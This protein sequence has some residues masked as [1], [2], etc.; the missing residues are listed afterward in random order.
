M[1]LVP[2][3]LALSLAA[4]VFLGGFIA[5][6]LLGPHGMHHG[7]PRGPGAFEAQAMTPEGREIVRAAFKAE[8]ESLIASKRESVRLRAQVSEALAAEPFDRAAVE[9]A[10]EALQAEDAAHRRRVATILIA[11]AGKLSPADRKALAE[12]HF[13]QRRGKRAKMMRYFGED[14]GA[15]APPPPAADQPSPPPPD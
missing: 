14:D 4:N 3:L 15:P 1:R 7:G 10:V 8:R 13:D 2:V 11:A 5:G 6:R 12:R 9:R